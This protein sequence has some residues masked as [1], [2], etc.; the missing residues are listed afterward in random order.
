MRPH[1]SKSKTRTDGGESVSPSGLAAEI[2]KRRPFEHVEEEAYLNLIRT[3]SALGR[4][5]STLLRRL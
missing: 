4:S 3:A 5:R 1:H 2:G